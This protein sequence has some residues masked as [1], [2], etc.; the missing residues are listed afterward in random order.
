MENLIDVVK[1]AFSNGKPV[2]IFDSE[3]R[4]GETDLLYPAFSINTENIRTLRKVCGGLLFL[5]IG[6]EIGDRLGLPYLQDLHTT[7]EA[8][9]Q[10]P[11]LENLVTNDLKYDQRSA[12]TLSLNHRKTFT[13]I[14]DR[15]RN[16]TVRSFA[17]FWERTQ[18][19]KDIA[20]VMKLFGEE[21]RTPG[22]VPVC[23]E[24][25]GGLFNRQGHTELAVAVARISGI[26]P[27]VVGAE[28]L[29]PD[30]DFALSKEQAKSWGKK[31]N[32]P[33]IS[34]EMLLEAYILEMRRLDE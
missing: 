1:N 7:K 9:S 10:W 32:I 15:D 18:D 5:A 6:D 33:F 31:H 22:H 4:E 17:E 2:L 13:G 29:Q 12:F 24:A 8:K 14:T 28:M 20:T 34:G 16:L 27:I 26:S 23:K 30:G 11:I 21:F 3:F 25:K 19:I